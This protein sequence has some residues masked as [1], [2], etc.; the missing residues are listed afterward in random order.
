MKIIFLDHQG[1]MLTAPNYNPGK[2]IDFDKECVESLNKIIEKTNTEI[3]ISSDWKYWVNLDEMCLF[4]L[5]QN[6]RKKPIDY[7]EISP[8]YTFQNMNECRLKEIN[9][10][11]EKNKNITKWIVVDDLK[12][13][14]EK[15]FFQSGTDGLK[16]NN[17]VE[18]IINYFN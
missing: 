7:T 18:K 12:L 14:N 4:Y 10:W 9:N 2:L 5:K 3:V 8:N 6:I 17:L 11:V 16:D 15:N 13:S 1:V